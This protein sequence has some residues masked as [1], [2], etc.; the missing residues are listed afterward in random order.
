MLH[1][2]LKGFLISAVW[3]HPNSIFPGDSMHV[4]SH[5]QVQTLSAAFQADRKCAD[6]RFK[7]ILRTHSTCTSPSISETKPIKHGQTQLHHSQVHL[8]QAVC[9]VVKRILTCPVSTPGWVA[10]YQQNQQWS[11]KQS[12][13]TTAAMSY[14]NWGQIKMD[15]KQ[16]LRHLHFCVGLTSPK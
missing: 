7:R 4:V 5:Q 13:P 16:H 3:P 1:F 12:G 2:E 8:C 6:L 11:V 14:S 15:T 9:E 10:E